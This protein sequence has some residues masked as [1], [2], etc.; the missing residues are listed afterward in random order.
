MTFLA[1]SGFDPI[2]WLHHVQVDRIFNM[3]Q[4]INPT[5]QMM[6]A[7]E[8]GTYSLAHN[9]IDAPMSPLY[10]FTSTTLGQLITPASSAS[11][12][13]FNY[14]YPE[15]EDWHQTP[16]QLKAN[17][18][19]QINQMYDPNGIWRNT[20]PLLLLEKKNALRA[21]AVTREW[22]VAV[23]VAKFDLDGNMFR[24]RMFL[25]DIPANPEDWPLSNSLIGT[26]S[27]MP[28]PYSGPAPFPDIPLFDEWSLTKAVIAAGHDPTNAHDV[29]RYLKKKLDWRVQRVSFHL[30]LQYS[31]LIIIK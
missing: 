9:N 6:G 19:A 2:F 29:S 4:A 8:P 30:F 1:Y 11:P 15:V 12:A 24:I 20:P 25:G 13:K 31:R 21:G 18:T 17:V 22:S 14:A 16:D 10:P 27:V 5:S 23:K 26:M 28:P 3:W 7:L